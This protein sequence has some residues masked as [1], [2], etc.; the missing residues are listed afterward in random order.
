M[1]LCYQ[2]RISTVTLGL[3][4]ENYHIYTE[5]TRDDDLDEIMTVL[6]YNLLAV[7]NF[8]FRM[9]PKTKAA[10]DKP[11]LGQPDSVLSQEFI[12]AFEKGEDD[13]DILPFSGA[14][15]LPTVE[16][17]LKL[18]YF[19]RGQAGVKN[20]HVSQKELSHKVAILVIKYWDMAGYKT[21][22]MATVENHIMKELA[23]YNTILKSRNRNTTGEV[24]KRTDY[25]D[26]IKKL[27]D[28]AFPNLVETITKSRLLGVDDECSR[29]RVEKGYT[30]KHE[31]VSFLLD[32]RGDRKMVMGENDAS[33]VQRLEKNKLRKKNGEG[34]S[35]LAGLESTSKLPP[36]ESGTES[37]DQDLES[38]EDEDQ[39]N[40][41]DFTC[42]GKFRK[43]TET[44]LVELPRDI[45][46]SPDVVSMLD[47]T[48]TT[49]RKAVGVVSSILKTG[50]I[51]GQQV[52]LSEFSLSRPGLE[53][54]RINNRTVIMEQEMEEF[55]KKKPDWAAIHFDGKLI[56]DI[57]GTKQ[58]NLAILVSGAPHYLEGKV[59]SVSKLM[60]EDGKP[61]S[62]GEAQFLAVMVQLKAWGVEN[63]IVAVVY[64]TTASNTGRI[65]GATVRLQKC[66]DR[67]IFF[68]ACRHH[69]GELVAKACWYSIFEADL[70]PDCKFF[71]SIKE[72]WENFDTS[73]EAEFKT[74]GPDVP[75]REEALAYYRNLLLKKNRRN[76]V[77][78]RDDYRELAECAMLVLG[79]TPPSG[80]VVWR[81]PGACHKARFMAFGIYSLKAF[82][83]SKQ[84]E[85][86][87]E[88]V[89]GLVQ[90]CTFTVTLYIPHF[91]SSSIGCDSAVNDL[92]F[93]KKLYN[94]RST[95]PQL[96]D[97]ALVVMR[98]H[99]WYL[100]PEVVPFSL[101]SSKLSKDEK[102][103]LACKLLTLKPQKP[104]SYK[105][106]KPKFPVIDEKTE[107]VDLLTPESFKFFSILN[108]D[109]SW[110]AMDPDKWEQEESFR[111]AERFVK[112]VKVVNDVAE[113]GVKL[114]EDYA[115]LLT[116][117]DELRSLVYQGVGRNRRMFPIFQKKVLNG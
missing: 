43:K 92:Q 112:T 51:D 94:Y 91:L 64:D 46:N 80:K 26:S 76:E 48:G 25:L 67:P 93:F 20:G 32:Q 108:L 63:N 55:A 9:P 47:R 28:I 12:L 42:K 73:S 13:P 21:M 114:A 27:F 65:K 109:D 104:N 29:Y 83:F 19:L 62:T 4:E 14:L 11:L 98:R 85:L 2:K 58:E 117:D 72:D 34:G 106:E 69:V 95:D 96:A 16:Q 49:S 99:C 10:T 102:S 37:V 70:T 107:L 77:F 115:N 57:T 78:I 56:K 8:R 81:K 60:D 90:F 79:E 44:V 59:L 6:N 41:K 113:R 40:D 33:Y 88:T 66:L 1:Y 68:L 35:G 87:D 17:V 74:L 61:T 82:A 71:V 105:L 100:M 18:F 86:D 3:P 52:D 101:F 31:D 53:R 50:K 116:K 111:L 15:K 39:E 7:M 103:L 84:L 45:M 24:K 110:L 97:E 38:G 36:Q 89:E 54:K 23:R 75:G 30:R 5:A 22:W